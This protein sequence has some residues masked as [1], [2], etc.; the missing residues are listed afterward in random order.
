MRKMDSHFTRADSSKLQSELGWRPKV[1][2]PTLV[3]MMVQERIRILKLS[4]A[5]R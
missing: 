4:I 5:S 1:D 3:D 2:F